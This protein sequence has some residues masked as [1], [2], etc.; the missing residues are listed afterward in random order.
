MAAG[1]TQISLCTAA[2]CAAEGVRR[3]ATRRAM[4]RRCYQQWWKLRRLKIGRQFR[5]VL[6]NCSPTGSGPTLSREGRM[7]V[8]S[9]GV[10]VTRM[11]TA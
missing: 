2:P 10:A 3:P 11:A 8:M 9:G 4:C 5:R 7:T 1:D 6:N